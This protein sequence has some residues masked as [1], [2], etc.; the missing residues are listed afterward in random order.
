S[1]YSPGNIYPQ[2]N[3]FFTLDP[4]F[5]IDPNSLLGH[6]RGAAHHRIV[7]RNSN[8]FSS[9]LGVEFR[10]EGSICHLSIV[11]RDRRDFFLS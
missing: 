10:R 11:F 3:L 2:R 7:F 6:K 5:E 1:L 9:L 4:T 8:G